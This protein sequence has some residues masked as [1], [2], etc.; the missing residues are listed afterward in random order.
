MMNWI[1]LARWALTHNYFYFITTIK[2]QHNQKVYK[3]HFPV[4]FKNMEQKDKMKQKHNIEATIL[5]IE[6]KAATCD[7]IEGCT[8]IKRMEILE[9][10]PSENI[11]ELS[12]IWGYVFTHCNDKNYPQCEHFNRHFKYE[13]LK[14]HDIVI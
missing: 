8:L 6:A 3:P 2:I 1:F 9:R 11:D 10:N 5:E 12:G 7:Y 14:S 13:M 4:Y